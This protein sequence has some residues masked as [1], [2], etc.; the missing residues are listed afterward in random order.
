[1][2]KSEDK[3]GVLSLQPLMGSEDKTHDVRLAWQVFLSIVSQHNL[4][5]Y[6]RFLIRIAE[7]IIITILVGWLW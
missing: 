2:G 4:S 3:S 1:M 6:L 5:T 7:L